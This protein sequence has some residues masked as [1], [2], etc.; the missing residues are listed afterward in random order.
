MGSTV[1][2]QFTLLP[3][4]KKITNSN[5]LLSWVFLC[6]VWMLSLRSCTC[7]GFLWVLWFPPSPKTCLLGDSKLAVGV[8]ARV[9]GGLSPC[10]SPVRDW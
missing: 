1:V 2:Q 5:F 9:F 7:V 4:S 6:G 3:H 10:V 8:D